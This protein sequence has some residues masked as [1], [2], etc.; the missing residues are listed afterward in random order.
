MPAP[1][2]IDRSARHVS[3]TPLRRKHLQVVAGRQRAERLERRS[4]HT[5][6]LRR[7]VHELDRSR[8]YD[9]PRRMILELDLAVRGVRVIVDADLLAFALVDKRLKIDLLGIFE[10]E[11][12]EES[13]EDGVERIG[14]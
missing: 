7:T 1:A 5:G 6:L 4:Q 14:H 12:V 2:A 8:T 3:R 13:G 9:D 10:L 11:R